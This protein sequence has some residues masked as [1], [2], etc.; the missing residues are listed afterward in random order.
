M[1]AKKEK[2]PEKPYHPLSSKVTD[3]NKAAFLMEPTTA[4]L[5]RVPGIGWVYSIAFMLIAIIFAIN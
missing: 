4:D 5:E 1:A 2:T 3:D